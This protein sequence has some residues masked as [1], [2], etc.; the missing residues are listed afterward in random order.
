MKAIEISP[1][2]DVPWTLDT[3][4]CH[5][6]IPLSN[7]VFGALIWFQ[8]QTVML[9]INRADYW[10]HRGGTIWRD[11]CTYGQ[12]KSLLESG[13]FQGARELF[14]ITLMNGK[15]KRPTR[16]AMGRIEARLKPDVRLVSANLHMNEGE[17][18][19]VCRLGE[20]EHVIDLA[21]LI[22]KP[23]LLLSGGEELFESITP[24]PSYSFEKTKAYF[25]DFGIP[26]PEAIEDGWVQE[27]PEDPA[28]A[29]RMRQR[30]ERSRSPRNTAL[31]RSRQYNRQTRC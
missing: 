26:A 7:G 20:R 24:V 22:D 6:G 3:G 27:L 13:D 31:I 29:V 18:R 21:V 19:V 25:D 15:E 10:D 28:C 16:L 11:D 17:V 12:L 14:P 1:S 4:Y 30:G 8:D 2:Y 23:M 9:T 5:D